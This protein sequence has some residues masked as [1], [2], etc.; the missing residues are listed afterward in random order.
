M[1]PTYLIPR[2]SYI[3][4]PRRKKPVKSCLGYPRQTDKKFE[5]LI[6]KEERERKANLIFFDYVCRIDS[7]TN[8]I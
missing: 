3:E 6:Q 8:G 5:S 2:S 1:D 7:Q 4:I